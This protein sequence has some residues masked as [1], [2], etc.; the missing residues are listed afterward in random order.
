MRIE[1]RNSLCDSLGLG[2]YELVSI[3]G[4]GGKTS[5]MYRLASE[6]AIKGSKALLSTTT[7]IMYPEA[8]KVATVILGEE[9]P[10][11]VKR[12]QKA[13]ESSNPVLVGRRRDG[14]KVIGFSPEFIDHLFSKLGC[15]AVVES[16]GA[17]GKSFKVPGEHEPPVASLTSIYLIVIGADSFSKPIASDYVFKPRHVAASLGVDIESDV[18]QTVVMGALFSERGYIAKKPRDARMCVFINKFEDPAL[19]CEC[20]RGGS[21]ILAYAHCIK[22][23]HRIDRVLLGS[24]GRRETCATFVIK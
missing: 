10:A 2:K 16:D 19:R 6:L 5:L 13:L 17:R 14:P 21:S 4:A 18:S 22:G 12:V 9:S 11:T 15:V 3:V 23:D 8:G 1:V 7:R 20:N 24:L